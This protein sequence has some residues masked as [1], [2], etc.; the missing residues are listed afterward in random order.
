MAAN[1]GGHDAGRR[2]GALLVSAFLNPGGSSDAPLTE[3][4][5]GAFRLV[6]AEEIL[7]ETERV[8]LTTPLR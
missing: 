1:A 7:A 5:E 3:A 8:L 4:R 2:S 6:L